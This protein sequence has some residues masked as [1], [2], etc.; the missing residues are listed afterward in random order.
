MNTRLQETEFYRRVAYYR[1]HSEFDVNER[2]YKIRLARNF[3][4]A[5]EQVNSGDPRALNTVE[6]ALRSR[7]NNIINWRLQVPL[8]EWFNTQP[9]RAVS[10]LRVL[11]NTKAS[12]DE[13]LAD[14]VQALSGGDIRQAGAQLVISSTLLMALSP[15]EYPPV[16][17][18]AFKAAMELA[19]QDTLYS[20]KTAVERYALARYFMDWMVQDSQR[21]QITLR[22][23]L[24]AQGIIWCLSDG[25]RSIPVPPDWIDN[26]AARQALEDFEYRSAL[27]ELSNEPGADKLTSTEKD[28]LV[29]SRRGQGKFREAVL[30]FWG[31]C[32]VSDCCEL[33]LLRASHIKPW[34]DSAN[35]ERLDGHNGLLLN[36]NL[37]A[38]F[39]KGLI[40]FADDGKIILSPIFNS[41]DRNALGISSTQRLRKITAAHIAYLRYHREHV[42]RKRRK[43][44]PNTVREQ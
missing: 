4:L 36:P 35:A 31:N 37:D 39:D 44:N 2:E 42:F 28:A 38:A 15:E 26:P 23:P 30:S 7:D 32:A 34:K 41:N 24:D 1:Y 11:W 18:E 27:T 6:Q 19:G 43:K 29:K 17:M 3:R 16:R 21:Y 40:T 25:W 5:S 9:E 22:D 14:F 12:T 8:F 13:R 10:S 33:T 20:A